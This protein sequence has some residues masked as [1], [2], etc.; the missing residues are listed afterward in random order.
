MTR[1]LQK[2]PRNSD[3][4][5]SQLKRLGSFK[6][7]YYRFNLRLAFLY[8]DKSFLPFASVNPLP[9]CF[10]KIIEQYPLFTL[11][12]FLVWISNLYFL[13]DTFQNSNFAVSFIQ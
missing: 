11:Y 9:D 2:P 1:W 7:K 6:E 8:A 13:L 3:F 12:F 4:Q 10:I 5:I